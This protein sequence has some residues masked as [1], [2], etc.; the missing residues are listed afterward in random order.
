MEN[1]NNKTTKSDTVK[2]EYPISEL[3]Q[4]EVQGNITLTDEQKQV[5]K[6]CKK[7]MQE[8]AKELRMLPVVYL[9]KGNLTKKELLAIAADPNTDPQER[10]EILNQLIKK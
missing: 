8:L 7:A 6:A 3:A 9:K 10:L 4:I 1:A 2:I 5:L